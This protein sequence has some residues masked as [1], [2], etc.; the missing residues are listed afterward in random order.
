LIGFFHFNG[1]HLVMAVPGLDPGTG[2]GHPA[3][4]R[5]GAFRVGI[6]GT[7]PVMTSM[8]VQDDHTT[9]KGGSPAA[10]FAQ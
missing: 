9:E 1:S 3:F 10:L 6:T 7:R 4:E 2:S 5:L 8:L